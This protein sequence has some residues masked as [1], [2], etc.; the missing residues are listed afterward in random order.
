ML[1]VQVN[2][3]PYVLVASDSCVVRLY[4]WSSEEELLYEDKEVSLPGSM[5]KKWEGF[6]VENQGIIV[7]SSSFSMDCPHSLVTGLHLVI[8]SETGNL[9]APQVVVTGNIIDFNTVS[10][11]S[12]TLLFLITEE[13]PNVLT[14]KAWNSSKKKFETEAIMNVTSVLSLHAAVIDDMSIK[15]LLQADT[16][17]NV[18]TY[19]VLQKRFDTPR[20]TSLC[21][22]AGKVQFFRAD[23]HLYAVSP[24]AEAE[25]TR[26]KPTNTLQVNLENND[27]LGSYAQ[28]ITLTLTFFGFA[29]LYRLTSSG[30]E[31]IQKLETYDLVSMEIA[32]LG[33]QVYILALTKPAGLYVY[34]FMGL[35]GLRQT[36]PYPL[37]FHDGE[38]L[39]VFHVLT[40]N[41][42]TPF[43]FALISRRNVIKLIHS[44]V[45]GNAVNDRSLASKVSH[46]C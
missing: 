40:W 20:R 2:D 45:V 38:S 6:L 35:S 29:Q 42:D 9:S 21:G 33:N 16:H 36:S 17:I 13:N 8:L 7:F 1:T 39:S 44:N 41:Y 14:V 30:E 34:K 27:R 12:K 19:Q 37:K 11:P 25:G 28:R 46:L 15:I 32:L 31:L 23:S 4:K 43:P 5:M 18:T 3:I 26:I 10:T 24:L 22:S